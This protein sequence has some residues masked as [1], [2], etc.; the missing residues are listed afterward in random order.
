M[1][2]EAA[3]PAKVWFTLDAAAKPV[4]P[5]TVEEL[6][7]NSCIHLLPWGTSAKQVAAAV[8]RAAAGYAA[9]GYI[10]E[11]QVFWKEGNGGWEKLVDIPDLAVA[12]KAL[13]DHQ[14]QHQTQQAATG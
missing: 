13:Q 8:C 3:D 6:A 2:G 9:S 10:S 5:Y 11:A 14:E 12:Y 4:G 1:T 7:G